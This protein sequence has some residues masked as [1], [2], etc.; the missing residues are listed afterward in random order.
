MKFSETLRLAWRTGPQLCRLSNIAVVT[1]APILVVPLPAVAQKYPERPIRLIAQ[2]P[3]G[4]TADLIARV[5]AQKL[6]DVLGQSVVTDNRAGAAGIVSA[7]IT[8]HAAPDGYTLLVVGPP[9]LST[10]VTLRAGKL[11][12]N[13]ETDFTFITLTGKV[14]LAISVLPSFPAKSFREFV[15]YAKA[16]PGSINYGSAGTGSTNHIAGELLK[17]EAGIEM[18]H[19]PFKGGAPAMAALLANQLEVYIATMPTI[20][21]M[22]RAGRLRAIAVSSSKRSAA[23]PD[24]PTI[25]ESGLLGFEMTSWFCVLGP[26]GM[27]KAIVTRLN[28]EIVRILNSAETRDRLIDAGVNVEPTTPEEL[29]TFVLAEIQKMRR[30]VKNSGA[31][32]D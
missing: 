27:P 5:I 12:Y 16:K 29:R 10:S 17:T 23:L 9:P 11:N 18:T 22:V 3:A 24:V 1:L 14:P 30:I 21:P 28:T 2:S 13:P 25:A 20:M 31:K 4:G 32:V 7:E 19:V 8:A 6:G 26:A 15:A